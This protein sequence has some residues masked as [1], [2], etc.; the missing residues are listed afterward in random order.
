MLPLHLGLFGYL[1]WSLHGAHSFEPA[2][3]SLETRYIEVPLDHLEWTDKVKTFNIKYLISHV[4]HVPGGPIFVYIGGKGNIENY[5]QNSGFIFDIAK[6]FGALIVFIEHRY[7]G[8]SLPFGNDSFRPEY[9]RFLTTPNALSDF[10]FVIDHLKK[11]M[12]ENVVALD[13]YPIVA[14]GGGYG[15]ALAAWLRMKYPFSVIGAIASSVPIEYSSS[16]SSCEC[17]YD[18]VTK[19]FERYGRDQCVKTIRLGWDVVIN[20]SKSKMGMDFLSTKWKLCQRLTTAEDVEK[21]LGWMATIYVKLSLNNYHYPTNFFTSLPAYPVKVF[22]D[23][24]TTSFFNDTKGL[25]EYFGQALEVYTNYSGKLACN[26]FEDTTDYVYNYQLCTELIM[27]KCSVDSDMFINSPWNYEQFAADC[28]KKYGVSN[29]NPDWIL[30]GY[31][32]KNVKYFSNIVLSSGQMDPYSCY[33]AK[34]NV[35]S[36]IWAFDIADGPHH[37]DL[38]NS[39]VS[40]NNYIINAR[41]NH[42]SAIKSWLNIA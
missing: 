37:I 39:D 20:L 34:T 1:L 32:G 2:G 25:V 10:V 31:G 27:P 11:E 36:S 3:Y 9:I 40:D 19:T 41:R 13:T 15:G 8:E 35:S 23:K 22:C 42:V 6:S 33:G 16:V 38:R 30:L 18:V 14:F 5:A 17:F 29:G 7:Y 26:E 4:Y 24:L 28:K 12:Y 21:L